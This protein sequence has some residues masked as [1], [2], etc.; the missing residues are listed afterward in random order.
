MAFMRDIVERAARRAYN[1]RPGDTLEN[2][3]AQNILDL[4]N[5]YL[6]GLK[7]DGFD[8]GFDA[9]LLLSNQFPLAYELEGAVSDNLAELAIFDQGDEPS[10]QVAKQAQQGRNAVWAYYYLPEPIG[11]DWALRR[12]PS[13]GWRRGGVVV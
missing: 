13:R 8:I 4:L 3:D 5:K 2:A 1:I 6:A 12:M 9:D 7:A 11:P 10:Q